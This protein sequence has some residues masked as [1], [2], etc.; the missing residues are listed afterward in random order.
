MQRDEREHIFVEHSIALINTR[1]LRHFSI[2]K[3]M[4]FAL[5]L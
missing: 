5:K 3:M 1:L 4:F 2:P